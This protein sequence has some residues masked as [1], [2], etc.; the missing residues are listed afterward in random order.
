M[1]EGGGMRNEAHRRLAAEESMKETCEWFVNNATV[2]S[3]CC[4]T[5]MYDGTGDYPATEEHPEFCPFEVEVAALRSRAQMLIPDSIEGTDLI[6]VEVGGQE[7][8]IILTRENAEY[9]HWKLAL[10]LGLPCEEEGA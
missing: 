2:P 5:H 6:T 3:W 1:D 8:D 7:G 9:L 4:N 10:I